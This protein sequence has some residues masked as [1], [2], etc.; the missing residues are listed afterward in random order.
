MKLKHG[1]S[2]VGSSPEMV[3]ARKVCAILWGDHDQELVVTGST[4]KPLDHMENSKHASGNAEDY[5][6]FYFDEATQ[7]I[8]RGQLIMRLGYISKHYQVILHANHHMHVEYDERK[9]I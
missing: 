7:I 9:V 3:T 2:I 8:I 4:E 5:R 1:V 6:V